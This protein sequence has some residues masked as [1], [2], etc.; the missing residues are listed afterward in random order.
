MRVLGALLAVGV[1]LSFGARLFLDAFLPVL[2]EV[3][4]QVE[5]VRFELGWGLPGL[6]LPGPGLGRLTGPLWWAARLLPALVVLLA[7]WVL[8][9]ALVSLTVWRLRRAAGLRW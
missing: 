2:Q 1:A 3:L 6:A 5:R 8:L 4:E 9:D 7:S